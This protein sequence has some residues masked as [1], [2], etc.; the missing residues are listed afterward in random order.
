[1][2]ERFNGVHGIP[3][4][5]VAHPMLAS[6]V[7]RYRKRAAA[8]YIIPG[9]RSASQ[10]ISVL[11]SSAMRHLKHTVVSDVDGRGAAAAP[12]VSIS[13]RV[14][15]ASHVRSVHGNLNRAAGPSCMPRSD[16]AARRLGRVRLP[17]HVHTPRSLTLSRAR[18][19]AIHDPFKEA[20]SC[21][22][23]PFNLTNQLLR[24]I[25][26]AKGAAAAPAAPQSAD[27]TP[28]LDAFTFDYSVAWPLSLILSKNAIIKYQLI[29]RPLLL[30]DVLPLGVL[31][32][33]HIG[34]GIFR[35]RPMFSS[36]RTGDSRRFCVLQAP[37]PLQARG[38][39]ALGVVA[40][41][42]GHQGPQHVGFLRLVRAEAA[43]APLPPEHRVLY[44][45]RVAQACCQIRE[46]LKVSSYFESVSSVYIQAVAKA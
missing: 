37:L 30:I 3:H 39:A 25:N 40:L 34:A 38:A 41:A 27:K 10:G 2:A 43:H 29:F 19:A 4:G 44:D 11:V 6:S 32:Q 21:D 18:Q 12:G 9:G 7:G 23:L 1:M 24:I 46:Q 42:A 31:V 15:S 33:A 8:S 5:I 36:S 35:E 17:C 45:V 28:G 13:K 26:A 16:H 22:L 14:H 20:L